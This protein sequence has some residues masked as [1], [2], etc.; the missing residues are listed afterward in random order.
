MEGIIIVHYMGEVGRE[1]EGGGADEKNIRTPLL[2]LFEG[3]LRVRGRL[4]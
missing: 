3:V 4:E 1:R 2:S